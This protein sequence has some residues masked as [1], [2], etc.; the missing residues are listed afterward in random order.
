MRVVSIAESVAVGGETA[1]TAKNKQKKR[2]SWFC[3]VLCLLSFGVL[4]CVCNA[5]RRRRK[6]GWWKAREASGGDQQEHN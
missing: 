5:A 1:I 2:S 6:K 4:Y 3:S